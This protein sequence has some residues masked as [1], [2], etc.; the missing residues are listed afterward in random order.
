MSICSIWTFF[1]RAIFKQNKSNEIF[2]NE[3]K[4]TINNDYKKTVILK[5]SKGSTS[6]YELSLETIVFIE[7]NKEKTKTV[8]FNEKQI[9]KNIAIL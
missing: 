4:L 2:K 1:W 9:I 7:N 6:E 3:F 5:D 8:S